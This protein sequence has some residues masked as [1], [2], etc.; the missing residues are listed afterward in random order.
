MA[1]FQ[2]ETKEVRGKDQGGCMSKQLSL[3]VL[4]AFMLSVSAVAQQTVSNKTLRSTTVESA[5]E[6]NPPSC[7]SDGTSCTPSAASCTG[8]GSLAGCYAWTP[9]FSVVN[10]RCPAA[11]GGTCTYIL[12]IKGVLGSAFP[13]ISPQNTVSRVAIHCLLDSQELCSPYV[14]LNPSGQQLVQINPVDFSYVITGVK[15]T[16]SG[17][18]HKIEV[19]RR[20]LGSV[21]PCSCRI[22]E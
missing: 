13:N 19:G 22:T 11:A 5:V 12:D 16:T 14:L 18:T 17:Q 1:A 4:V 20:L 2:Q 8:D 7:T 10:V 6:S 15:N 21:R 3:S 9:L